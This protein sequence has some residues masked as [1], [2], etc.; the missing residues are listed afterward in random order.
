MFVGIQLSYTISPS[1]NIVYNNCNVNCSSP[2]SAFYFECP[3]KQL[4]INAHIWTKSK[5]MGMSVGVNLIGDI[6]LSVGG[7]R[8]QQPSCDNQPE[9]IASTTINGNGSSSA[10]DASSVAAPQDT[11]SQLHT[12]ITTSSTTTT[13]TTATDGVS[14]SSSTSNS[15][16]QQHN[17]VDVSS[18]PPP[19]APY[20]GEEGG[21]DDGT[22]TATD[23]AATTETYVLSMPS[24]YARSILTEPWAELGGRVNIQC[25]DTGYVAPIVFHTK[26]RRGGKGEL[27]S[28]A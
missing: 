11:S 19:P 24:A 3:E 15:D 5:F 20:P 8:T 7:V 27:Q 17:N 12:S 23:A 21:S 10:S 1:R 25:L 2:V 22:A 28:I 18:T 16:Q 9:T 14:N 4:C 26:V 6:T 13:T